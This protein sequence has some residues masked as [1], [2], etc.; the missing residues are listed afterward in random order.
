MSYKPTPETVHTLDFL[1]V[2]YT[3]TH[4]FQHTCCSYTDEMKH[5]NLKHHRLFNYEELNCDM[6]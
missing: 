6:L 1:N 3:V 2:K 4:Q 5:R